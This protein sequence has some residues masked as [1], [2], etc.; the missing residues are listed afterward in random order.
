[1]RTISAII[2]GFEVMRMIRCGLYLLTQ[3]GAIGEIPLVNQLFGLLAGVS[4]STGFAL[5]FSG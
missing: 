2:K 4:R 1:M 5:P 3:P